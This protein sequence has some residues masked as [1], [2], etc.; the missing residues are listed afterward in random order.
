MLIGVAAVSVTSCFQVGQ[1]SIIELIRR[2]IE[3]VVLFE[4][5]AA[6]IADC[7]A[8]VP[9]RT[10]RAHRATACTGGE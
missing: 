2:L 10:A 6:S 7:Q 3:G 8:L 4:V 9:T 5:V 1:V